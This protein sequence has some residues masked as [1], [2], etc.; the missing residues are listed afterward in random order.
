MTE[1]KFITA[2]KIRR[3]T[4]ETKCRLFSNGDNLPFFISA[5]QKIAKALRVY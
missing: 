4:S 1:S 5:V 2:S 3:R